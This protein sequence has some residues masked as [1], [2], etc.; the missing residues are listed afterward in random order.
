MRICLAGAGNMGMNHYR[1]LR[2]LDVDVSV[3][4]P[5]P[6]SAGKLDGRI[7]HYGSLQE[8]LD[9]EKPDAVDICAPT[10]L[11]HE[12]A[13][14]AM[15]AGSDVFV[16]KPI[17]S[18]IEQARKMDGC[19]KRN[20]KM[21]FVGHIERFNPT[22]NVLKK[23]LE[24]KKGVMLHFTRVGPR[25][26]QI[27]DAGVVLDVGIHDIDLASYLTG[28]EVKSVSCASFGKDASEDSAQMLLRM[29]GDSSAMITTNWHTPFKARRIEAVMEERL[30][31]ADLLK[32]DV[33][34][35]FDY[36]HAPSPSFRV[37]HIPVPRTE[38]LLLE[39]RS[40]V[41]CAKARK[42]PPFGTGFAISALEAVEAARESARTKQEVV[43]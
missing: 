23:E 27:K 20:G 28:H 29:D 25:P 34:A 42:S 3:C 1:I 32:G 13:M 15:E 38:P 33:A 31:V 35:Y 10:S 17:A 24:G 2:Q 22:V 5:D 19:A 40:F 9:G 6:A 37:Q 12:L 4:D 41:E 18:N 43:L 36:K 11:H 16:E 39:L 7:R 21:L 8:A 14:Q 26:P 30:Y